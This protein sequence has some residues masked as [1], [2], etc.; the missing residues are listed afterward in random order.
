MLYTVEY[1]NTLDDKACRQLIKKLDTEYKFDLTLIGRT[2]DVDP[3]VNTLIALENRIKMNEIE[4][5]EA[6][7]DTASKKSLGAMK[8]WANEV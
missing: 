8:R 1:I 2:I 3:I 7:G 4:Q 5:L 6:A